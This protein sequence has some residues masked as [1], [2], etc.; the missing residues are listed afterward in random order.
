MYLLEAKAPDT[1]THF[2][3]EYERYKSTGLKEWSMGLFKTKTNTIERLVDEARNEV[4]SLS[5]S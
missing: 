4:P 1:R 3:F 2:L 5:C